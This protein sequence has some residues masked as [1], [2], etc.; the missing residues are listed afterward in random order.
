MTSQQKRQ[1]KEYIINSDTARAVALLNSIDTTPTRTDNQHAALFL[2]FSMIEHE[3][4]NAGITW[5]EIAGHTYQLRI[6]KEGLHVMAKQLQKALWGTTST[7]ELKKV[8]QIEILIEHFVD[9]FSKVGLELPPF[10]SNT[11]KQLENLGG[12]KVKAGQGT[13]G[14]DYPQEYKESTI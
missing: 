7:K 9:L 14:V 10:P 6:T 8:G 1:L 2:W 13:E 11:A 3:A 4:E 12:Y 5:N